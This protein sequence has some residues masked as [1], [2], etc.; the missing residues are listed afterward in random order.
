MI[1]PL[2]EKPKGLLTHPKKYRFSKKLEILYWR[3]RFFFIIQKKWIT[4]Q[5]Y[6][7]HWRNRNPTFSKRRVFQ[8]WQRHRLRTDW[9]VNWRARKAW[10]ETAGGAPFLDWLKQGGRGDPPP[11]HRGWQL[12]AAIKATIR[13]L[14]THEVSEPQTVIGLRKF[15]DSNSESDTSL[16]KLIC[17]CLP[18][19]SVCGTCTTG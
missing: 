1:K 9:R 13:A 16:G 3:L 8:P 2:L 15:N 5:F 11:T 7:E 4:S 12:I 18:M 17:N 10:M 19:C 6:D 14:I